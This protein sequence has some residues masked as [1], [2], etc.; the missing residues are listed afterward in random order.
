M[1]IA[2]DHQKISEK[3]EA[4]FRELDMIKL[5]EKANVRR[6]NEY[7]DEHDETEFELENK[8]RVVVISVC[9]SKKIT[10]DEEAYNALI[11]ELMLV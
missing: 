9:L 10:D 2:K 7:I 5:K 8:K 11:E 4:A 3:L 1:F 6:E